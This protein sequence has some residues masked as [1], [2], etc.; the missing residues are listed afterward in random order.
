MENDDK[1]PRPEIYDDYLIIRADRKYYKIN[2]D[3]LIYMEGQRAYVTFFT[4][5]DSITALAT[6]KELEEKLPSQRFVRIHKSYIVSIKR[7]RA[8]EGNSIE[9]GKKYLPVGKSYKKL[10][11]K[12]FGLM[13]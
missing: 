2:Y 4:K 3:D 1:T 8:L 7:I 10:V 6:L 12:I 9:I 11:N 13:D 5:Q